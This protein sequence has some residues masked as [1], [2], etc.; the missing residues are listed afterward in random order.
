MDILLEAYGD[1]NAESREEEETD[2]HRHQG[3]NG[4]DNVKRKRADVEERSH[5]H[6][7][8]TSECE[9]GHKTRRSDQPDHDN[10]TLIVCDPHQGRNR[11]FPH[12]E[13]NFATHVYI[14]LTIPRHSQKQIEALCNRVQM[15]HPSLNRIAAAERGGEIGLHMSLSRTV[16][17]RRGQHKTVLS[18]LRKQ[19][20]RS[21][22]TNPLPGTLKLDAR[23][24]IVLVNDDLSRTFLAIKINDTD[25][26]HERLTR[27][28]SIVDKVFLQHGLKTYYGNPIHHLSIGWLLGDK[29]NRLNTSL[30]KWSNHHAGAANIEVQIQSMICRIGCEDHNIYEVK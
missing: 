2:I 6:D 18:G 11:S 8:G 9:T 20:A 7:E 24:P 19:F 1:D 27:C 22:K 25:V 16:P 5:D 30:E 14:S 12:V 28:V 17:T 15:F 21:M 10:G 4:N 26:M 3:K 13:G 23:R 29:Q